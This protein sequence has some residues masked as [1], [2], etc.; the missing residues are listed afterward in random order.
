MLYA[1]NKLYRMA[2]P[3]LATLMMAACSDKNKSTNPTPV[4]PNPSE[5]LTTN[6][7]AVVGMWR[8]EKKI[9]TTLDMQGNYQSRNTF[10][11]ACMQDDIFNFRNDKKY[12]KTEG[13][14]SCTTGGSTTDRD[15]S[16]GDDG[17]F[18]YSHSPSGLGG[19]KYYKIDDTHFMVQANTTMVGYISRL[20]YFYIKQ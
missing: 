8:F 2:I 19:A 20:T 3:C 18:Y 9:D 12:T 5:S 10:T 7:K 13:A 14:D 15:W 16:I 4:T 6:E 11:N 17:T 1:M